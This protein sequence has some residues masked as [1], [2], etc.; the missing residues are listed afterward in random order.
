[1]KGRVEEINES[2]KGGGWIWVFPLLSGFL[3]W[4]AS[5]G[6]VG[7]WPLTVI[8]FVPLLI[9]LEK[10]LARATSFFMVL[11]GGF[12]Y[13]LLLALLM[14][15]WIVNVLV[16]YGGL[17]L[18]VSVLALLLLG[19]YMALYPVLFFVVS[20]LFFRCS[21]FLLLFLLPSLWTGLEWL[22]S[23]LFTGFP[24]MDLGYYLAF[25]PW[26]LQGAEIFGHY[27]L[28]WL[29]FFCNTGLWLLLTGRGGKPVAI[30]ILVV[31]LCY[32]GSCYLLLKKQDVEF[33]S[34]RPGVVQGNVSQD[35]KW[36]VDNQR[37]TITKYISYSEKLMAD[38]PVPDFLVWPETA[39]PFYLQTNSLTGSI[40]SLVKGKNVP[41]ITGTPWFEITDPQKQ[42]IEYYNA[43]SLLIPEEKYA[44]GGLVLKSHLVPFGEYVPLREFLPFLEPLVESAGNLTAGK[45]SAP[46]SFTARFNRSVHAGVLICYESIFSGLSRKWVNTGANIL[47][48]LTNDA[49]YGKT[50]APKH[51]LA[52]TVLRAV[53]TRRSIVRAANTGFS[54]FILPDGEIVKKTD[55]FVTAAITAILPL[56]EEKTFY[57]R[58]GWLFAPSC[59]LIV[60]ISL[61]YTGLHGLT[62]Q[63]CSRQ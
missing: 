44:L 26:L 14:L 50:S 22:R 8:A 27:G 35:I 62:K 58:Y 29:L 54:A 18:I 46:L 15:Y 59:F 37:K 52:M 38:S 36:N 30:F 20:R 17:S 6:D 5:P 10:S 61:I 42:K 11:W 34:V 19:C 21:S 60:I 33:E 41:L 49:W 3:L 39:V 43:A 53:E 13:G 12:S 2:G 45:I 56:R 48:N 23:W 4:L 57:V 31:T 40:L 55:L 32:M 16:S 24:W 63:I 47:I 51:T 7:C 9:F 25:Q 1:M 28:T